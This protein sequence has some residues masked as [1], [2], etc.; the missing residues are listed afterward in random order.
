MRGTA[1]GALKDPFSRLTIIFHIQPFLLKF[2]MIHIETLHFTVSPSL[3]QFDRSKRLSMQAEARLLSST[4][5]FK[6]LDV[7]IASQI[8]HCL[9]YNVVS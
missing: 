6:I 5:F 3:Q 1:S 8:Y 4:G 7:N 2:L 9:M